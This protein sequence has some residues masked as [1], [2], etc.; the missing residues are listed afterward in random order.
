MA[1]RMQNMSPEER[2][3]KGA[4]RARGVDPRTGRM[5]PVVAA[6]TAPVGSCGKRPG[7]PSGGPPSRV[8]L[9]ERAEA[10]NRRL[11]DASGSREQPGSLDR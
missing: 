3:A 11:S 1:E 10:R 7:H 8:R 2:E 9:P 6:G 5:G 4:Q